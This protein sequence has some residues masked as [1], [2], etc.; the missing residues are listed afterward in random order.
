MNSR[1]LS[2]LLIFTALAVAA[3]A[4]VVAF[5]NFSSTTGLQLN[6][7]EVTT[8]G[9]VLLAANQQNRSGSFFT[10][11][12]LDV[13]DFSALFQFRISSPGGQNDGTSAG[14][15]GLALV[16]QR[17]AATALGGNGEA[18]GYGPRGGTSAIG[19][20]VAVEFDTFANGW[21]PN[22]NHIGL[23][24]NGSLTSLA[25]TNVA[26]AFDSGLLWTVW[27]DYNGTTLEVRASNNGVRPV[28]ATL[29]QALDVATT[30][31][32]TTAF[33]GFTASTGSAYGTHEVVAFAYSTNYVEG[34]L[35]M[36]PEPSTYALL[37]LGL[38]CVGLAVWRRRARR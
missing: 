25:S 24:L 22:S 20:S 36:V 10:S 8:G 5:P 4:Q 31:G 12:Q 19:T 9:A 11:T 14:A 28:S 23:N 18:L 16:M 7:A 38:G 34:G 6:S 2:C 21:D 29:A 33:I 17:V 37:A 13:T 35:T 26:D 30:I 15:D 3:R 1:R 32:G 27:V